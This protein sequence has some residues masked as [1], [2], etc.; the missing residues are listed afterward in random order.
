MEKG[1][2]RLV[3]HCILCP[4]A[5]FVCRVESG[6]G[7]QGTGVGGCSEGRDSF[8]TLN[9]AGTG[10]CFVSFSV[11]CV[12]VDVA[13][14][15]PQG[16]SSHHARSCREGPVLGSMAQMVKHM[17]LGEAGSLNV[18]H[19]QGKGT[20]AHPSETFLRDDGL[21]WHFNYPFDENCHFS[22]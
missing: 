17:H 1:S 12:S 11:E 5:V 20:P 4:T 13:W 19:G 14:G 22:M 6:S 10:H 7:L 16:L 18:P 15:E 2:W 8:G 3:V 9:R 21:Q